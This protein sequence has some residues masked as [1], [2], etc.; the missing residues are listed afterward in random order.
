[1]D[2]DE[3]RADSRSDLCRRRVSCRRLRCVRMKMGLAERWVRKVAWRFDTIVFGDDMA[4]GLEG[5]AEGGEVEG[6][7]LANSSSLD[8]EILIMES[9]AELQELSRWLRVRDRECGAS[10]SRGAFLHHDTLDYSHTYSLHTC[11]ALEYTSLL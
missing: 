2:V 3:R 4:Q 1:M 8:I 6:K 9:A 5:E 11:P 7:H 10:T